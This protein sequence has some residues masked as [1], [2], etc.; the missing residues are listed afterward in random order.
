MYSG[1]YDRTYCDA[2]LEIRTPRIV[3]ALHDSTE[4]RQNPIIG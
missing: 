4:H 1:C 3:E 2:M